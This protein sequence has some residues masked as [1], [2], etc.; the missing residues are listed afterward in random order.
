MV[1]AE[2]ATVPDE[3]PEHLHTSINKDTPLPIQLPDGVANVYLSV[4]SRLRRRTVHMGAAWLDRFRGLQ[5]SLSPRVFLL[6]RG[7][8]RYVVYVSV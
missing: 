6:L 1:G 7:V 5:M 3:W 4:R 2:N 8:A